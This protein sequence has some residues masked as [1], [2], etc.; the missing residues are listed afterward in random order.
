MKKLIEI[1]IKIVGNFWHIWKIL[2]VNTST[3]DLQRKLKLETW[4]IWK[5]GVFK[6]KKKKMNNLK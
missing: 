1:W 4:R 2:A 3:K 6:I 5:T